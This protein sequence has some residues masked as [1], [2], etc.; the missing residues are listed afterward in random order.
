MNIDSSN[1]NFSDL[2]NNYTDSSNN[3]Y[4]DSSNNNYTDSSNNFSDSSNNN[5]SSNNSTGSS[6]LNLET[7]KSQ[8]NNL[9]LLYQQVQTDY[10]QYLQQQSQNNSSDLSGNDLSGNDLSGN[11]LSGNDLSGNDLSGN[12]LSGNFTSIPGQVFWGSSSLNTTSASSVNQC[13]ALCS[14]NSMCSGATYNPSNQACWLRS[15]DG[16]LMPSTDASYVAIVPQN[17]IYLNAL[18][19]LNKQLTNL[20]QQ[21]MSTISNSQGS[22]STQQNNNAQLIQHLQS[23]Y[24]GLQN[25]RGQID[26][27]LKEFETLNQEQIDTGIMVNK[28]Y[29]TFLFWLFLVVIAAICLIML[30][31]SSSSNNNVQMGGRLNHNAYYFILG[32][33]VLTMIVFYF[34]TNYIR[35]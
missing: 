31:S 2:S 27:T 1:N 4:T 35:K 30:S 19:N 8:Y 12:D 7:L 22:Y 34:Y 14:A 33:V 10:I 21:I 24:Q 5:F 25:D 15:G 16:N 18:S 9:L 13:M 23:Q 29:A 17:L 11:D 26:I 28:Y 20:N 6:A 3:N 32:I